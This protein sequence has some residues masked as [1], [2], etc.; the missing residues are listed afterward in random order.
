MVS[1][2]PSKLRR[3]GAGK[4]CSN[5]MKV[6]LFFQV[7]GSLFTLCISNMGHGERY[8]GA[9]EGL[10]DAMDAEKL[11]SRNKESQSIKEPWANLTMTDRSLAQFVYSRRRD[12]GRR[13]LE[14]RW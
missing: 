5:N 11:K 6:F 13:N 3:S 7:H 8:M 9:T 14:T 12:G 10:C 4:R 1:W 2:A